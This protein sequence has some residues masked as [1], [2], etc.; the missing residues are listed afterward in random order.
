MSKYEFIQRFLSVSYLY[1]QLT[2]RTAAEIPDQDLQELLEF[3][4]MDDD[5]MLC[6]DQ[7]A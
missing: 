5:L 4:N 3:I 1:F 6:T 2:E 7:V